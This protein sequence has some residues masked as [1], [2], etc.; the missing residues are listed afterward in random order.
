LAKENI[1]RY[2]ILQPL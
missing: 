2:S 1:N